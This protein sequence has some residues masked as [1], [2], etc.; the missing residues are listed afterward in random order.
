MKSERKGKE[1][2]Y[3]EVKKKGNVTERKKEAKVIKFP[4]I[5]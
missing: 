2:K 5:L 1:M 4:K 3:S